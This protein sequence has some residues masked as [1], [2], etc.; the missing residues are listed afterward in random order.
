MR[1]LLLIIVFTMTT[2]LSVQAVEFDKETKTKLN[3]MGVYFGDP[4]E[5]KIIGQGDM[6]L[7]LHNPIELAF[8]VMEQEA[9]KYCKQTLGNDYT[10]NFMKVLGRYTVYFSCEMQNI[11]DQYDLSVQE[12]KC[13]EEI[14]F[15]S[16]NC[17]DFNKKNADIINAILLQ[18]KHEEK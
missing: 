1:K 18:T 15:E 2:I 9:R 11:I 16:K 5:N 6:Y 3:Q 17:L 14:I 10:T 13:I 12:K 8:Y 4:S 7:V